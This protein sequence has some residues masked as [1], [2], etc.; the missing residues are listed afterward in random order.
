MVQTHVV[1]NERGR[2]SSRTTSRKQ[3]TTSSSATNT[4]TTLNSESFQ[5]L[6]TTFQQMSAAKKW[7]LE[8]NVFVEDILFNYA[9]LRKREK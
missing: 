7:K 5:N 9:L 4:V 6:S 2:S 8:N 1:P 3:T